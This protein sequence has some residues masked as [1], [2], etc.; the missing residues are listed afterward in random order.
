[1][2]CLV[3]NLYNYMPLILFVCFCVCVF[4]CVFLYVFSFFSLFLFLV[5]SFSIVYFCILLLPLVVNKAYQ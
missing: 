1:M 5:K 4:L 3:T 2:S